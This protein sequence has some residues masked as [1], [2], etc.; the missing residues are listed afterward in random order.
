MNPTVEASFFWIM[1]ALAFACGAIC[2]Q[3]A[4]R[5]ERVIVRRALRD[6]LELSIAL[7][8]LAIDNGIQI[9]VALKRRAADLRDRWC[10]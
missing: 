10:E 1:V 4:A 5:T 9:P 6:A 8:H 2:Q 3:W 7:A